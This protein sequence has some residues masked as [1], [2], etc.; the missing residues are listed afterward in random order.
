MKIKYYSVAVFLALVSLSSC[1]KEASFSIAE[2]CCVSSEKSENTVESSTKSTFEIYNKVSRIISEV[3]HVDQFSV[4]MTTQFVSDL[5]LD[6][7]EMNHVI[8]RVSEEM[9]VILDTYSSFQTVGDMV[10]LIERII[11]PTLF[12][13]NLLVT[14][15]DNYVLNVPVFCETVIS[16]KDLEK[17]QIRTINET[18]CR[19]DVGTPTLLDS[20][21]VGR[22]IS[23]ISLENK[24]IGV[25]LKF[26]ST[27]VWTVDIKATFTYADASKANKNFQFTLFKDIFTHFSDYQ[28]D[29]IEPQQTNTI[30]IIT[31][32]EVIDALN[33]AIYQALGISMHQLND[34][35]EFV[36]DLV[37]DTDVMQQIKSALEE[38]L[39]IVIPTESYSRVVT[40]GDLKALCIALC[41]RPYEL[42]LNATD[43]NDTYNQL[44]EIL[45]EQLSINQDEIRLSDT[46][47]SLGADSLDVYEIIMQVESDFGFQIPDS[48]A[49]AIFKRD[50]NELYRYTLTMQEHLPNE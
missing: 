22:K 31:T 39:S 3:C 49:M 38:S 12:T 29:V 24:K 28:V 14:I 16:W 5:G 21:D 8:R 43:D 15:L 10:T 30:C 50:V 25:T 36:A 17:T 7:N 11:S 23:S 42:D 20:L 41:V 6:S 44:K 1:K 35:A 48:H 33:N 47:K 2:A 37:A 18:S 27:I 40:I 26:L 45:S 4:Q 13:T 46:F 9:N 32:D 34:D 19:I